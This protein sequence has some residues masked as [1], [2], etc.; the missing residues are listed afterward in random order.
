M[1]TLRRLLVVMLIAVAALAAGGVAGA[2]A[3]TQAGPAVFFKVVFTGSGQYSVDGSASCNASQ[4]CFS[5]PFHED[6]TWDSWTATYP[7]V[8]LDTAGASG[9]ATAANQQA[10]L[11]SEGNDTDCDDASTGDCHT[12]HCFAGYDV[13]PGG[14]PITLDGTATG[15]SLKL[16]VEAPWHYSLTSVTCAL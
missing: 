2:A 9:T 14:A 15:S 12:D 6:L 8:Q 7:V 1:S 3:Q 11:H 5:G 4:S 10:A 13:D 16:R